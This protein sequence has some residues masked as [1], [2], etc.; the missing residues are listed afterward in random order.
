MISSEHTGSLERKAERSLSELQS[1]VD[2]DGLWQAIMHLL[3]NT[4]PYHSCSLMLEIAD[5]QPLTA[6]HHVVADHRRSYLPATSLSVSQPFLAANPKIKLYTYSEIVRSDPQALLRRT[7]QEPDPGNW[8][9]FVHLSFWDGKRP[10][11]VLSV[12]RSAE[13]GDFGTKEIDFLNHLYPMIECGLRR[14]QKLEPERGLSAAME[15]FIGTIPI[16]VMFLDASMNLIFASPEAYDF[17]AVWNYGVKEAR[18]LNARQSFRVPGEI[19]TACDRLKQ[20]LH[21]ARESGVK[22]E[23]RPERVT[24]AKLSRLSARIEAA[25]PVRGLSA[26]PVIIVTFLSEQNFDGADTEL[27]VEALN[28]LQALTPSERRVALL[29][30]EGCR[31]Q[32]VALKIGKSSRTVECQLNVIYRKLSIGNRSQLTRLLS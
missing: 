14:L 19:M 11:A 26:R 8:N 9:Q 13:Q 6:R 20:A 16:P 23:V 3:R 17:C 10:D 18:S 4:M 7:M 25:Q 27:P 1:A 15:R 30:A 5:Y 24:H 21:S 31:S 28:A 32:E 2:L 22:A 29:V 12:R